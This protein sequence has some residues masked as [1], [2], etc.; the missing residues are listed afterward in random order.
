M[1]FYRA[2]TLICLP[3]LLLLL[4]LIVTA[5]GQESGA[6]VLSTGGEGTIK[7]GKEEF[8]LHAVVAKLFEDGKVEFNLITDMTIF[9]SGTWAGG[10]DAAKEIDIKISGN[11]V[12][13][14]LEG[15]GK[16]SFSE[17]Q[18]SIRAL[19]LNVVNKTSR[20]A[21]QVDFTAKQD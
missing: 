17:D 9:V 18:K 1:R 13:G 20:R 4:T 3:T 8:K 2:Q 19:K 14:N 21:I 5:V 10:P 7:L 12:G 16:M 11:V 6:R 15:G